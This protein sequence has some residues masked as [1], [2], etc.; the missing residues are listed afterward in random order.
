M[1]LTALIP[2]ILLGSPGSGQTIS[3]PSSSLIAPIKTY[4]GPA[5]KFR[6]TGRIAFSADGR[7]LAALFPRPGGANYYGET[8]PEDSKLIIWD[9]ATGKEA[10]RYEDDSHYIRTF[11]FSP[12]GKSLAI[13]VEDS[14]Y[15][16]DIADND[17]KRLWKGPNKRYAT[18]SMFQPWTNTHIS[19]VAYSP[20]GK[21]IAV[22]RF[23]MDKDREG[24]FILD[25]V[26]GKKKSSIFDK[27]A[28][29]VAYSPDGKL[30]AVGGQN[31]SIILWNAEANA[32]AGTGY[33][34]CNGSSEVY[35]LGFSR[36]NKL[37][38]AGLFA[39]NTLQVFD[40]SDSR[41]LAQRK[42]FT[43]YGGMML[44]FHPRSQILAH[45][46]RD[47]TKVRLA[48]I[49]ADKSSELVMP[50][51][52]ATCYSAYFAFSPDGSTFAATQYAGT[53]QQVVV[54][55]TSLLTAFKKEELE[56]TAEYQGRLARWEH[57]YS[58]PIAL[59]RYDAD[60]QGFAAVLAGTEVFIPVP[61]EAAKDLIGRKETVH[62]EGKLKYLDPEHVRLAGAALVDP[63]TNVRYAFQR[64][65]PAAAPKPAA[66][67]PPVIEDIRDIPDF[68]A[69]PRPDD[70]AVVI[71]VENY[72][73]LPRAEYAGSDAVLVKGYLKALG[74]QER[75]IELLA[76]E[77][78]TKSGIEKTLEAWLPN[79]VK[80]T[81]RVFVYYSGH[82]APDPASGEAFL[83]PY[84]GD[85]NYLANTGY[86]L[87]RLY[88]ALGRMPAA[89][90]IVILDSCF[91]GA[92]GR[93]V[94]AKGARP[95]VMPADAGALPNNLA[96]LSASQGSQI[97]TSSQ[98]RGGGVFTYYLLKALK[99]GRKDLASIYEA[100]R[101]AVEDEAKRLNVQQSPKLDPGPEKLQGRFS[102]RD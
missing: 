97:S 38:A 76:N 78:A 90:V 91:S 20:D 96:V 7:L 11:A 79:R 27:R 87:K 46:L 98:E 84:D 101:P 48:D 93:S 62:V 92:G 24:A 83:V 8:S 102:L 4:A 14:V 50:P 2:L 33:A 88:D 65:E 9:L 71:G 59:G 63:A 36:D 30:L 44:A 99:D 25:A 12:D 45:K 82:G 10:A 28:F 29:S 31:G 64:P 80:K 15:R 66:I 57:P 94:L 21:S 85:P 22:A 75:N 23:N 49:P 52:N 60:K 42:T 34:S 74:F 69:A 72:Q 61:R 5:D 32:I 86:P 39:C 54:W 53:D 47:G 35:S 17:R 89:E 70:H 26:K 55:D 51:L 58:G 41:V 67:A 100:M 1:N 19:E 18:G 3:L 37:L 81:S 77:R 43:D 73:T 40:L 16:W 6:Q 68:K 56:S 95:L 13:A